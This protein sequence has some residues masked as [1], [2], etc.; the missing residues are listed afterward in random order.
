MIVSEEEQISC[1]NYVANNYLH[2]VG[3]TIFAGDLALLRGNFDWGP[4]KG[5]R[6][7]LKY[8]KSVDCRIS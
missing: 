3:D 5:L 4:F 2:S 6:S 8:Y 7:Y 1:S